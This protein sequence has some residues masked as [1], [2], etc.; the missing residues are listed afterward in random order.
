M[1]HG[2]TNIKYDLECYAGVFEEPYLFQGTFQELVWRGRGHVI[3][4]TF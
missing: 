2:T 1:M 4:T 3:V